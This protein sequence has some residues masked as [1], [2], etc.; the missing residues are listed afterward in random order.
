MQ[1][2][3]RGTVV[4]DLKVGESLSLELNEDE[5]LRLRPDQGIGEVRFT[6]REKN[7][8]RARVVVQ[9]DER[10]KVRRKEATPS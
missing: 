10:V 2:K 6:L 4:V 3:T 8:Q 5:Q 1:A 9:A 7:G